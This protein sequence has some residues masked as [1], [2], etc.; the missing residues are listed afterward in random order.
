MD[1]AGEDET[2]RQGRANLPRLHAV[3]ADS[4]AA[5]AQPDE[6]PAPFN[7]ALELVRAASDALEKMRARCR[8]VEAFAQQEIEYHR[9]QLAT[10]DTVIRELDNKTAAQEESIRQLQAQLHTEFEERQRIQRALDDL[11]GAFERTQDQL[12]AAES[13]ATAAEA[14]LGRLHS[15]I[16][17]AFSELPT[18]MAAPP[19]AG[20]QR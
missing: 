1:A 17:S 3:R 6:Q 10:A 9:S 14:W 20:D 13:R 4:P 11:R 16:A 5:D 12:R 19:P 2:K 8:E 7:A 18:A 15:E